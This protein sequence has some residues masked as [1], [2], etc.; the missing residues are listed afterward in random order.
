MKSSRIIVTGSLLAIVIAAIAFT[1]SGGELVDRSPATSSSSA[2]APTIP[3]YAAGAE[4]ARALPVI[5]PTAPVPDYRRDD[6][7]SPWADVDGNGC[8]QRQ[9]VLARDLVDLTTDTDGCTVLT[10]TLYD[11]YTATTI[12]FQHDRV[13]QPGNTG[14]QAV[15]IDHIVSLSAA[16]AGGAWEWP[17]ERRLEFANTFDNLI[18]SDG[19]TNASK[20]DRGPTI[21]MPPNTAYSCLY[22]L[23]YA[24][25]TTTWGLGVDA[26]DRDALVAVLT[27]CAA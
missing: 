6:F 27:E 7:G 2:S 10:G 21:W 20:G 19:P 14:S 1:S 22:A 17:S 8:N 13:A 5:D 16:N 26:A 4:L 18:A 9:D 15:Q 25:V 3:E 11:P 12:N 24:E 23:D